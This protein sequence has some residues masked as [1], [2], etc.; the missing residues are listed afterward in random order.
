MEKLLAIFFGF[1]SGMVVYSGVGFYFTRKIGLSKKYKLRLIVFSIILAVSLIL[2][3]VIKWIE[4][5]GCFS[6]KIYTKKF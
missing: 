2:K 1:I 5:K 6:E 4:K 3:A